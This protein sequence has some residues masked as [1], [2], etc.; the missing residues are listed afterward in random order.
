VTRS[1]TRTRRSLGRSVCRPRS[2]RS[3]RNSTRSA[4]AVQH[5]PVSEVRGHERLARSRSH[6]GEV[7][8]LYDE[9]KVN[10]SEAAA[11]VPDG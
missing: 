3:T 1:L 6:L 10:D 9:L 7:P 11:A 4:P 8:E 2:A 5:Q